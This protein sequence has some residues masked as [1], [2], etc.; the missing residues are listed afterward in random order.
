MVLFVVLYL[1]LIQQRTEHDHH[2]LILPLLLKKYTDRSVCR[3]EHQNVLNHF[4]VQSV[5]T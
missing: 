3:F 2:S 1:V 5:L 4:H